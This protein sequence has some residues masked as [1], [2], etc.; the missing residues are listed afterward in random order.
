MHEGIVFIAIMIAVVV[1]GILGAIIIVPLLAS[2]S[3]V[4]KYTYRRILKLPPWP[5]D[6]LPEAKAEKQDGQESIGE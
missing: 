5:D 1:Q 4:G 6:D 3:I 2:I